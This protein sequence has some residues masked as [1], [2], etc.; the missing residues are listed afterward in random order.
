[1]FDTFVVKVVPNEQFNTKFYT[2]LKKH[3]AVAHLPKVLQ[4][5]KNGPTRSLTF[6]PAGAEQRPSSE[7]ELRKAIVGVLFALS[8]M[9]EG[10]WVHRDIRWPNVIRSDDWYLIDFEEVAQNSVS[11]VTRNKGVPPEMKKQSSKW[12]VAQDLWQV[13]ELIK[14]SG[15]LSL[16]GRW[17]TLQNHL[18]QSTIKKRPASTSD[19]FSEYPWLSSSSSPSSPS[20]SPSSSPLSSGASS[21]K[22]GVKGAKGAKGAAKRKL[23]VI[24]CMSSLRAPTLSLLSF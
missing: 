8:A 9:H 1:M 6:S 23:T 7:E 13:G 15:V 21:K 3:S 24:S 11:G 5:K 18:Q 22:T 12:G 10:H 19:V 4:I 16:P 20:T 17:K 14:C 2:W